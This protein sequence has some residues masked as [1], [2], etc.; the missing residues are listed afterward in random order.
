[1]KK[2]LIVVVLSLC[3]FI[4]TEISWSGNFLEFK[5]TYNSIFIEP[6]SYIALSILLVFSILLFV[7]SEIYKKWLKYF[8]WYLPIMGF[9]VISGSVGSSYT[10]PSRTDFAGFFGVILVVATLIFALVQ[11]FV[12]KK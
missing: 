4:L 11:K 3:I 2:R 1:M 8:Y 10:W 5:R 6:V 9:F 12:Y 7:N